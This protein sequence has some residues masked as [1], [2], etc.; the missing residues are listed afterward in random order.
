MKECLSESDV[1]AKFI[2]PALIRAGWYVQ[3]RIKREVPFTARTIY[4][5][6]KLHSLGQ[7]KVPDYIL[8]YR[9]DKPVAVIETKDNQHSVQAGIQQAFNYDDLVIFPLTISSNNMEIFCFKKLNPNRTGSE[10]PNVEKVDKLMALC[11]Q[12]EKKIKKAEELVEVMME[13]VVTNK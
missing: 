5:K 1:H 9:Q 4:V 12:I 2:T 3:F 11:D 6:G 13:G 7:K 10:P 8:Y